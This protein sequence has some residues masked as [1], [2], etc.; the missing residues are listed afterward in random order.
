VTSPAT[1]PHWQRLHPL[2]PIVYGG[3]GVI[4]LVLYGAEDQVN[5]GSGHNVSLYVALGVL[6][7]SLGAGVVKWMV[8][9]WA[10]DGPVLRIQTG[11]IRR[12]ARQLPLARIQAVDVVKPFLARIFGL[13][14]LRVRLAGNSRSNGRIAYLSEPLAL[15]LRA[16]LL[17]GHHGLDPSTPEPAEQYVASVPLG[18][19]VGSVL[20]SPASAIAIGLVIAI[21]VISFFSGGAGAG[22]AGALVVYLIAFASISWRKIAEEYGFNIGLAADGI[23]VK[24]G[25]FSTVAETIPFARVQAVRRVEPLPWRLLGWCRLEVDVAGSP[26]QEQGRGS[27]RTSRALLP[28]GS[29]V[30]A[31]QMFVSLLG[32][33]EFTLTRPSRR[34][35][36]KAPLSYHFLAGGTDGLVV[37]ASVGRLRKTTTWV[38]LE[39]VQSVR[40]VQ[41][42]VQRRFKLGTVHVDAAGRRVSCDLCDRDWPEAQALFEQVVT[43]SRQARLRATDRGAGS[44]LAGPRA[45]MPPAPAAPPG[46]RPLPSAAAEG[47]PSASDGAP[48]PWASPGPSSGQPLPPPSA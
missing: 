44:P 11:L 24:R 31:D 37:A 43:Q 22:G 20:L 36:W 39:K 38:P 8:T 45:P 15:D 3:R 28:V 12:D 21:A 46:P 13:A 18:Q 29:R 16:R 17:A 30:V 10:L 2:T 19:L 14:E 48:N 42:P 27:G 35:M 1:A 23:R 41:G 9:E 32:L 6:V 7:L 25:L 5:S 26:G 4:L 34:A 33:R 40:R 47:P